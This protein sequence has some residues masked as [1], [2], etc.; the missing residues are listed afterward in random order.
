M[1]YT[2]YGSIGLP[3]A[4]WL[5]ADDGYDLVY[6]AKKFSATTLLNP[7]RSTI[8][9]RRAKAKKQVSAVDI[10]ELVPARLGHSVHTAAEVSW[11]YSYQSAMEALQYPDK[12][13]KKI[14]INPETPGDPEFDVYIER[15]TERELD[16][17]IISGKF[18][19]VMNGRVIDIKTTKVYNWIKGS[20]DEKYARQGSI[21]RWL[22]PDIITDDFMD[23][24]F[25]FTDWSPLKA[26]IDKEY[27]PKRLM[28]RKVKLM[29]YDATDSFIKT[30]LKQL[31]E[32]MDA[33]QAELPQCTPKELWMD[34]PTWAYYKNT[35]KAGSRATKLYTNKD[36]AYARRANEGGVVIKRIATPKFCDYCEA[37][38][39]CTQA[40]KFVQDGVL[41]E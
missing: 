13:I 11:R 16:G 27:P 22:N 18:D 36:E 41:K 12:V 25:L 26:S 21:Y 8:L 20:N 28:T 7:V 32:L 39:I 5:A 34:P 17:Y 30:K 2:N 10:A 37:R 19:F 15:R 29:S 14:R 6:D 23:I 31:V 9:S 1:K 33:P 40:A 35:P 24:E 38:L 3:L 4:I